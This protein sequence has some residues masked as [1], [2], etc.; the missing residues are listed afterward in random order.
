MTVYFTSH[1]NQQRHAFLRNCFK[2]HGF[3]V[4]ILYDDS[5]LNVYRN[6]I[7]ITWNRFN[8]FNHHCVHFENKGCKVIVLENP[9]IKMHDYISVGINYHNN[10]KHAIPC[11]DD[12]E[13]FK[14][15]NVEVKP[16][17]DKGTHILVCTQS[18]IYNSAGNGHPNYKQPYMWDEMILKHI[19]NY[20]DAPIYFKPHPNGKAP[21]YKQLPSKIKDIEIL[22]IDT[23]IE[24]ILPKCFVTVV[25]TSNSATNS[26]L[27]GVPVI[28]TGNSIFLKDC[29]NY[30]IQSL[31]SISRPDNRINLLNR[32][33]WNQFSMDEIHNGFMMKCLDI[34][35]D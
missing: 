1:F 31:N 25:H 29:S 6:D 26:I 13:R 27:N 16:W 24:D 23:K 9:Y 30:G 3:R 35:P 8:R 15:F 2:D 32:M 11:M 28:Y 14:S 34:L 18:K 21:E 4:G 22:D 10:I 12:G 5:C 20:S 7:L 17:N 19:R 33:A